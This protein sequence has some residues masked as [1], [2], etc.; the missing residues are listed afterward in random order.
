MRGANASVLFVV[1]T[2]SFKPG[3]ILPDDDWR[4]RTGEAFQVLNRKQKKS[5]YLGRTTEEAIEVLT[6]RAILGIITIAL[7]AMSTPA[8]G[9]TATYTEPSVM[10]PTDLAALSTQGDNAGYLIG[11]NQ[12]L[13]IVLDAP[14]ATNS[15]SNVTIFTLPP[16]S[17]AA[18]ARVRIGT[19][20]NGSPT[21]VASRN[22][23]AGQSLDVSN[24]FQSGCQ[25]LGGCDYIEIT[26]TFTRRG[27]QGV[28]VDYI[29]VDGELVE[30]T[31]A[32]PEPGI[33]ALLIIGFAGT[34]MRL[35]SLRR[36]KMR[37]PPLRTA[38]S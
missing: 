1:F 31:G 2:N 5:P 30:V 11:L 25:L 33:W 23:Q 12:T 8:W 26:T 19:Y 14:I 13:G 3:L 29:L 34:A 10:D 32:Q 18:R 6:M 35:K 24:I 4:I 27:A 28:E 15:T 36:R 7:F 9:M 22:L 16:S 37:T 21:F 20:N 17:G 38:P